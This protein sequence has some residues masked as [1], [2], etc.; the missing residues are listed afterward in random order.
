MKYVPEIGDIVLFKPPGAGHRRVG[1]VS[2][3]V[4]NAQFEIQ[5]SHTP[6][7]NFVIH[8]DLLEEYDGTW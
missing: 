6:L 2:K 7:E 4:G 8:E 3:Y 1:E 5:T